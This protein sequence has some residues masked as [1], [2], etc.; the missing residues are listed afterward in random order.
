MCMCVCVCVCVCVRVVAAVT[1]HPL[2][3]P[4]DSAVQRREERGGASSREEGP[5]GS[6]EVVGSLE[7]GDSG[8]DKSDS[9]SDG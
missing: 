1:C 9:E 3:S 4:I 2:P 8:A 6:K 7:K 5:T